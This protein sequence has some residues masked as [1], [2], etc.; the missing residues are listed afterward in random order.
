[1]RAITII[2][3]FFI[4][5]SFLRISMDAQCCFRGCSKPAMPQS[6]KCAFHRNRLCCAVST[7]NNQVYARGLCVR[8][9]GTKPCLTTGCDANARTGGYC[10]RHSL[11]NTKKQCVEAGCANI[12]HSRKKCVRH[13]GGRKCK[14]AECETLA[15][16]A[17]Y[18]QRHSKQLLKDAVTTNEVVPDAWIEDAMPM[19]TLDDLILDFVL[20]STTTG[21]VASGDSLYKDIA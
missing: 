8:H 15:R 14:L 2:E 4:S 3:S 19:D 21:L 7:C 10:S 6:N 5:S 13:G 9:G 20:I 1:M 17:G 11:V 18:C 16:I 12:A